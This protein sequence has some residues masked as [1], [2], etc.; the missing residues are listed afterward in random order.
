MKRKYNIGD[1]YFSNGHVYNH[2][3]KKKKKPNKHDILKDMDYLDT[4]DYFGCYILS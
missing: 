4:M 1:F 2:R 3:G